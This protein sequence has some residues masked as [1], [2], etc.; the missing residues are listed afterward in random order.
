MIDIEIQLSADVPRDSIPEIVEQAL[1]AESLTITMRST[2]VQYPGCV[3][4]HLKRGKERGTLEATWWPQ[5]N[6]LWVKV[7]PG[8]EGDWIAETT[9]RLKTLIESHLNPDSTA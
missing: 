5:R 4:W 9:N 1:S 3:H 6:R 8:C 2:L 7:A